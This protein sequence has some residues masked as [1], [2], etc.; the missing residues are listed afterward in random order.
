MVMLIDLV[1]VDEKGDVVDGDKLIG[2][3]ATI[4]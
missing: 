4:S 1:V 2:A 3:M